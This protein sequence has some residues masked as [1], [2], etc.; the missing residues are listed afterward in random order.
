MREGES[1]E[2]TETVCECVPLE[3]ILATL[4]VNVPLPVAERECQLAVA[5]ADSV[6]FVVAEW[7]AEALDEGACKD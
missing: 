3:V 4:A 5:E 6:T 7:V 2:L 1:V